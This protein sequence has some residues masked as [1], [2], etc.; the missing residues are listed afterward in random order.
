MTIMN[1]TYATFEELHGQCERARAALEQAI[2][3]MNTKVGNSLAENW[4]GAG[5]EAFQAA[6]TKWTVAADDL[7]EVLKKVEASV[8]SCGVNYL[9]ME[10]QVVNM[11]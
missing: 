10:N 3:D 5:K 2:S 8:D 6:E 9:H 7:Y 4:V 1:V 11:F